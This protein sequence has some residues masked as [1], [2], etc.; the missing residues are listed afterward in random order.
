MT[1]KKEQK[2][3][4]RL[5]AVVMKSFIRFFT[6]TI[7]DAENIIHSRI[8]LSLTAREDLVVVQVNGGIYSREPA[9]KTPLPIDDNAKNSVLK[10]LDS[11]GNLNLFQTLI[12]SS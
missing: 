5:P 3:K 2:T 9:S 10:T 1:S 7:K 11:K 6:K 4:Q 8:C 12:G